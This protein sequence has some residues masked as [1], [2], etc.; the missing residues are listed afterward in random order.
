MTIEDKVIRL[1]E[2]REESR[3]GGGVKRIEAQHDKGKM[4]A[5]ERIEYFFD[6]GT[7]EELDPFRTHRCTDFGLADNKVLGDAV[8]TGTVW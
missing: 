2:L 1:N 5:R 8:V 7:F 4:T 6:E 3:L